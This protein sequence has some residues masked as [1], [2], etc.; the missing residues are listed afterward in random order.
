MV[1]SRP[2]AGWLPS[3]RAASLAATSRLP[4]GVHRRV[5]LAA[6]ADGQVGGGTLEVG[7]CC[8]F[9]DIMIIMKFNQLVHDIRRFLVIG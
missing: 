7:S 8:V 5:C 1:S 3:R 4:R 2:D 9:I 6:T